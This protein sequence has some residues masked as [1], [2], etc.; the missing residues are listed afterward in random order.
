MGKVCAIILAAGRGSRMGKDIN[1]QFLE[2]DKKPILFY[3]LKTF[4]EN[5]FIDEIVV[6][7]SEN[8]IE[9]CETKI[10][11]KYNIKK[12]LKVVKG[13]SER[14]QSVLNGLKAVNE[15]DIVLI[16]DGARP[17]IDNEII[18]DGIKYCKLYDGASCGVTPKDT[19]KIRDISSFSVQTPQRNTLF[20]VQTPQCFN[21]KIILEC[22]EK[23]NKEN[24]KVTDDTMVF[25]YY[26]YRVYLYEG[27]YNNIKI[28]TPEDLI[29]GEQILRSIKIN[30][31]YDVN[32]NTVI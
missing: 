29:I 16:H 20:C 22:H 10:I 4:S 7:A 32:K 8:E 13:G 1:K 18:E 3:A 14:Q 21:Y 5:R 2:I 12:V 6:V 28:T 19:I 24:I 27:S 11:E 15:C 25:E 9:Y 31:E 17:F 30:K 26:G 23:L